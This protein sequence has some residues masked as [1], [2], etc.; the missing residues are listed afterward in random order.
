MLSTSVSW[1]GIVS[2]QWFVPQFTKNIDSSANPGIPL[3]T[4][5]DS[6]MPL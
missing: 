6:L 5:L 3:S 4:Q 1:Q 2:Y